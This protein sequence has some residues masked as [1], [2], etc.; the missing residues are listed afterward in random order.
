MSAILKP[1]DFVK[2]PRKGVGYIGNVGANDCE[3]SY[4][5]GIKVRHSYVRPDEVTV[6]SEEEFIENCSKRGKTSL[7]SMGLDNV[8]RQQANRDIREKEE[9]KK[10][11]RNAKEL[12][13]E[14][15]RNFAA[16]SAEWPLVN[17]ISIYHHNIKVTLNPDG[18]YSMED[19]SGG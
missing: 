16:L 11:E 12:A 15:N 5:G 14:Y 1:G 3:F 2:H 19:T 10:A 8:L 6:I 18:T 7:R 17:P 9:R 13:A 4:D